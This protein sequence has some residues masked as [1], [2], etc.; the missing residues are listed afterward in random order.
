MMERYDL[1]IRNG[2]IIDGTGNPYFAAD[3]GIV[4][5]EIAAISRLVDPMKAD[6]ILDATGMIVSPGFKKASSRKRLARRSNL[7]SVV[8][9]KMVASGKKV[10]FVP[11]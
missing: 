8:S 11:V 2:K 5:E 10:I 9:V 4:G 3:I 1:I 7:N 6:R